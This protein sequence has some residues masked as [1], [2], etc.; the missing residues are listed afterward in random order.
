MEPFIYTLVDKEK[1]SEL[2]E[3]LHSCIDLPV[4]LLDETGKIL[5]FYGQRTVYCEHFISHISTKNA[6]DEIH[7]E[8]GKRAMEQG[9]AYIFSCHSNLSHIVFPLINHENL[10]GSILI[11]PFLMGE[12]DSTLV[13]DVGRRYPDFT[14]EDLMDLYDYAATVSQV[15][16]E[17]VTQISRL[18]YYLMSNLLADSREQFV[19]NQKKLQQQA[20][21]GESIQM[22]KTT[23]HSLMDS[24]PLE[25][26]QK[27]LSKLKEGNAEASSALLNDLLGYVFLSAGN[28]ISTIK[29]RSVELCSLLSR[30][31]IENGAA[32][33]QIFAL[34]NNFMQN[35]DNYR[36]TD[37][38]CYAM[39]EILDAFLECMF[40]PA[41]KN[42]RMIRD[43][44]N[45]I[46]TNF[47]S[48]LTLEEVASHLHLNPTYFSRIFK[49]SFGSS[50]KEYLTYVR[51]EE[52][53]RLLSNTDYSLLDIAIAVGFDNQSYF[54]SVFKKSTGVTPG[55]YRK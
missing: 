2:L 45:Y 30:A 31:A 8:A 16:P 4:Q 55:Q 27:L 52:A 12:A 33:N 37:D 24:Y 28:E 7:A 14:M 15:P 32:S 35:M 13:L 25:T 19:I 26:E 11:G 48:P 53:K 54:T 21:I 1:I 36:S 40:P 44:M 42:N 50:F 18:L 3:A 10:F 20:K 47:S 51:I 29:Y 17:K 41:V 34:N 39:I 9:S 6:C 46:S 49:E 23:C 22:Y 43:A 5:E 38:L